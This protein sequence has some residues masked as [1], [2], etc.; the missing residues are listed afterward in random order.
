MS[1]SVEVKKLSFNYG[2]VEILKNLDLNINDGEFMVLLG[3]S[4]CGKTTLLNCIAGLLDIADGQIWIEDDNVTWKEPKDRHIG[5]VFQSYALYPSMTVE[6]N[7]SFG[8]R[9]M[10]TAKDLINEKINLVDLPGYG[11]AKVSKVMRDNLAGLIQ[12]YIENQ[13]KLIQAYVLID[14]R[15]GLK[16]SDIDMFDLLSESNR[17]FSIVFT[18]S[19]KLK[20]HELNKNISS[21]NNALKRLWDPLPPQFISSAINQT[22]RK[23]ILLYIN[24]LL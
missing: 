15:V 3:P 9:M 2:K 17:K 10:G 18:K 11:Y 14:A 23:D 4:G 6:K 13:V 20:N 21:I 12:D 24:D 5:M 22:G 19:D 8:L 16:N 1:N 7:L